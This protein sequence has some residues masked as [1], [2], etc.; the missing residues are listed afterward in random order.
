MILVVCPNLAVD[1]TLHVDALE[2][3]AVHRASASGRQ[4]GGKGVNVARALRALGEDPI[5]LG[6]AGGR[7]GREIAEG[8]EAEGIRSDLVSFPG[9][10]RTCTILLASDGTATVVNERGGEIEDGS[11]LIERF[12]TWIREVQAIAL[13]G[14]LPPGLP[15]DTYGNLLARAKDRGCLSLLDTSGEA[16]RAGLTAHPDIAK[17]NRGEAE[18]LLG[19]KLDSRASVIDAVR[20]IRSRGARTAIVTLGCE[21][22]VVAD[23]EA[24]AH[25]S[26]PP[27]SDLRL[28]NPT[29]AGDALAAGFLAGTTRGYSL[30][31][32]S[33]LAAASAAASLGEGYGRF[34]AR[35]VRIEAA[36]FENL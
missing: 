28:G 31:D 6:F 1:V 24:L 14:S 2:L 34:R 3:G 18:E 27:S 19:R 22:F 13:M 8:L 25:C 10:S 21:G 17:P 32:R 33:R 5:V 16:L 12:D 29:G 30:V 11:E 35:D 23:A 4:A 9:E 26:V 7:T 15:A 36:R 20:E